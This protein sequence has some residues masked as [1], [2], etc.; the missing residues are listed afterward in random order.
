M[1][2][3][4]IYR[5]LGKLGGHSLELALK[6]HVSAIRFGK[7]H[8]IL[9]VRHVRHGWM[10]IKDYYLLQKFHDLI[11]LFIQLVQSGYQLKA[12]VYGSTIDV[13]IAGTGVKIPTAAL[14]FTFI[15]LEAASI[16]QSNQAIEAQIAST[17]DD[18][19][20]KTAELQADL[21]KLAVLQGEFNKPVPGSGPSTV[22]SF[23]HR[24]PVHH[25]RGTGTGPG[26]TPQQQQTQATSQEIDS[27]LSKIENLQAQIA[28]DASAL[29]AWKQ[30]HVSQQWQIWALL[31][32]TVLPFGEIYLFW[33]YASAFGSD[34]KKVADFF[35]NGITPVNNPWLKNE[36]IGDQPGS[37]RWLIKEFNLQ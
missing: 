2:K 6:Y 10:P 33:H 19:K 23:G 4:G 13:T 31:L 8:Q 16:T 26:G 5:G 14:L 15:T 18:L 34:L 9:E 37:I 32:A 28:N 7:H 30:Q 21:S 3:R 17:T 22:E 25:Q 11:P 20:A 24:L 36:L 12:W 27:L 35:L 1:T 29:E